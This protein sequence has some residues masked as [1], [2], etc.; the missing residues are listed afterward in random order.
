MAKRRNPNAPYWI[1]LEQKEREIIE[2]ALGATSGSLSRAANAL[3]IDSSH[4][5]RVIRR[6]GIDRKSY[7]PEKVTT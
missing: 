3:G 7:I 2:G 4:L 5:S 6:L 1:A